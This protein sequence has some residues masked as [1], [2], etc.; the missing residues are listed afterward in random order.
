MKF[1][2][3][4]YIDMLFY[5]KF[6]VDKNYELNLQKFLNFNGLTNSFNYSQKKNFSKIK[7]KYSLNW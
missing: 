6:T 2:F 7:K 1:C 4:S 3:I 5:V